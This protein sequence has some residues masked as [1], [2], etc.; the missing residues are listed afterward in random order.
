MPERF[1]KDRGAKAVWPPILGFDGLVDDVPAMD[2][3]A[4]PAGQLLD[5]LDDGA[6]LL[7]LAGQVEVPLRGAMIPQEIMAAQ[8]EVIGSG[9][10]GDGVGGTIVVVIGG[11]SVHHLP[12]HIVLGNDQPRL[13]EHEIDKRVIASDLR[14]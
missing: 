3:S 10:I 4:I 11:P 6:L 1:E 12:F 14:R 2:P 9:K 5:V 8:N 7:P 13:L